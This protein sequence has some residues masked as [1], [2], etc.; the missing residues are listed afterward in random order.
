MTVVRRRTGRGVVQ[1]WTK[2]HADV[3]EAIESGVT[4]EMHIAGGA[5]PEYTWE[6]PDKP[7]SAFSPH[8]GGGH[9]PMAYA[10]ERLA[11]ESAK[12][13][14]RIAEEV[15]VAAQ[16]DPLLSKLDKAEAHLNLRKAQMELEAAQ[17][18]LADAMRSS[19]G[20]TYS[21]TTG[22]TGTYATGGLIGGSGGGMYV[23]MSGGGGGGAAGRW[24][25]PPLPPLSST[26][27]GWTL[28]D[29]SEDGLTHYP[30]NQDGQPMQRW[31]ANEW[32][33]DDRVTTRDHEIRTAQDV[34]CK[35]ACGCTYTKVCY[36]SPWTSEDLQKV[37][38]M[39]CIEHCNAMVEQVDAVDL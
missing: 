20:G 9:G 29:V 2:D 13:C 1:C 28:P 36:V 16:I 5:E 34:V 6:E 10:R 37:A 30:R 23:T 11:V 33:G 21:L 38:T 31:P 25:L 19:G 26:I 22:A 14:L 18:R 27:S 32:P 24:P 12:D 8:F 15:H 17:E 3:V 35:F 39:H 7:V 4:T